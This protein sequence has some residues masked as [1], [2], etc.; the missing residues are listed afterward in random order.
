MLGAMTLPLIYH[1]LGI[2]PIPFCAFCRRGGMDNFV[3]VKRVSPGAGVRMWIVWRRSAPTSPR[4][5]R[6]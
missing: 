1:S 5:Q 3:P 6:P 4:M 2:S